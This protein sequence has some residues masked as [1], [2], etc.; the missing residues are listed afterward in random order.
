[1]S[2]LEDCLGHFS[3]VLTSVV[4]VAVTTL[5]GCG[6]FAKKKKVQPEKQTGALTGA[7]PGTN[8]S[9]SMTT[10]LTQ[11][12]LNIETY[13]FVVDGIPVCS[14]EGRLVRGI[15]DSLVT[16]GKDLS[17]STL[18]A[19]EASEWPTSDAAIAFARAVDGLDVSFKVRGVSACWF[20]QQGT[21]LHPAYQMI[22]T[23]AIGS[24]RVIASDE[25]IFE[26]GSA[27]FD[28]TAKLS[29]QREGSGE[30]ETMTAE[31]DG[32]GYLSSADFRTELADGGARTF[33][34]DLQFVFD[35]NDRRFDETS[36]FGTATKLMSWYRSM[37]TGYV[38]DECFPVDLKLHVVFP[39]GQGV[40]N[41]AR[42][43]PAMANESG[44]PAILLGDGDGTVLTNLSRDPDVVGHEFGHH[45][46][47]RGVKDSK[48]F[49]SRVIHEALADYLVY[50]RTGNACIG[51]TICPEGTSACV[52]SSC[53]RTGDNNLTIADT[54][55]NVYRTSQVLSGMLWD[56]QRE[57]DWGSADLSESGFA[58]A[59]NVVSAVS[60]LPSRSTFRD[61]IM[62]LL[63]ANKNLYGGKH[64]CNIFDAAVSRGLK[65]D[66][67][68]IDCSQFEVLP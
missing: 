26:A 28:A 13:H 53:L 2:G 18:L 68:D 57:Q 33:A 36:A 27:G 5:S 25:Q 12:A 7:M 4:V 3:K 22:F 11:A 20:L 55:S 9:C 58:L 67:T 24:R 60:Y 65:D 64:A 62:S 1:M 63:L 44:R 48:D 29:V 66:L 61:L 47:F 6:L 15:D 39:P 16:F 32:S 19:P 52:N 35:E 40:K 10:T 34:D 30:T 56:L 46:V 23:S 17:Q 54:G 41:N 21:E 49:E 31:T 42:Y 14:H 45:I 38:D 37:G 50:A 51:E 59:K 8:S 43:D